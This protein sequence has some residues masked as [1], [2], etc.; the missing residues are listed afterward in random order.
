MVAVRSWGRG[1]LDRKSLA[2]TFYFNLFYFRDVI[3]HSLVVVAGGRRSVVGARIVGS[4]ID[5]KT[6]AVSMFRKNFEKSVKM[7]PTSHQNP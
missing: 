2:I 1:S 4:K 3:F 5:K 6:V 7:E